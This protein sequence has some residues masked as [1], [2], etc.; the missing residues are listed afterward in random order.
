MLGGKQTV[1][2]PL[3]VFFNRSHCLPAI[4]CFGVY[5]KVATITVDFCM[6]SLHNLTMF[7]SYACELMYTMELDMHVEQKRRALRGNKISCRHRAMVGAKAVPPP[8]ISDCNQEEDN[9][10]E[11]DSEGE[12]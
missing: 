6:H 12:D 4:I 7:Y 10:S 1:K 11:G 8:P 5:P 3:S 2:K 9:Y